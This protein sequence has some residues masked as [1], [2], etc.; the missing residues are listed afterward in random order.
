MLM[1]VTSFCILKWRPV[2]TNMQWLLDSFNSALPLFSILRSAHYPLH[3]L[4]YNVPEELGQL[5]QRFPLPLA[6]AFRDSWA[7]PSEVTHP[8]GPIFS[9]LRA[10][11]WIR[12][13]S[14]SQ[15][16]LVLITVSIEVHLCFILIT[17]P[18]LANL[19]GKT[20]LRRA[21]SLQRWGK[22]LY[23]P[24]FTARRFAPAEMLHWIGASLV[25]VGFQIR[26][27]YLS[28]DAE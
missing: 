13:D 6:I 1:T 23:G 2:G 22:N 19:K 4:G 26:L 18:L 7:P 28:Q 25:A 12:A 27:W 15:Q 11:L 9:F 10:Q 17:A 20:A 8:I 24:T 3:I 5:F 16:S 14:C 21:P